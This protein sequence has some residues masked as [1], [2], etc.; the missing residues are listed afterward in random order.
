MKKRLFLWAVGCWLALPALAIGSVLLIGVATCNFTSAGRATL[1]K[2]DERDLSLP[3][4]DC[5]LKLRGHNKL[6]VYEDY[7]A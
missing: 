5:A 2:L 3:G 1:L 6:Y 4:L 7:T